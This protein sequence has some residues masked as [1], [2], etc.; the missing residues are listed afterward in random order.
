[1]TTIGVLGL[2]GAFREHIRSVEATGSKAIVVKRKEQ[3]E[4]IDG[5][6]IPGGESTTI[7]R[8]IDRYEF[9]EPIRQFGESGKPIFGTCAGLILLASEIDGSYDVHL[10]VM[11]IKVRRNA[12]GR[13]RE[14]FEASLDIEGV[15]DDFNAVF[16]RAPY[17]EG[18]GGNTKVLARYDGHIVA[19]QQDQYLACSFHPELTDDHR[20]TEHFV[21][22]VEETNKT[23]AL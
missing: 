9:L 19:A 22:M 3:L 17:I 13:Q 1:M 2:Q 8:L 4:E 10:G 7:R 5:L 6:I 14:S 15:A 12:F 18:V 20:L 11:D 21:K 16:I 23:L